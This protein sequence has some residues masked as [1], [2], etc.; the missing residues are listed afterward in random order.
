MKLYN[1]FKK[2]RDLEDRITFLEAE[3]MI[4]LDCDNFSLEDVVKNVIGRGIDWYNYKEMGFAEQVSYWKDIQS[5]LSNNAFM[6]EYNHYMAEYIKEMAKDMNVDQIKY[7]RFGILSMESFIEHLKCI[8]NPSD[9]ETFNEI[10][11]GI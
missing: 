11:E 3:D 5:I 7:A 9:N 6:N 4:D 8:N 1:P 2:I 10:N